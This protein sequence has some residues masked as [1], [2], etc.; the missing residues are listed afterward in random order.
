MKIEKT[1]INEIP[2]IV[3]EEKSSKVFIAVHGNMSNKENLFQ[4]IY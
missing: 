3:W 4:T 2:S 1:K